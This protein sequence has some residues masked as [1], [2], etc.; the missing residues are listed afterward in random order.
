MA[1]SLNSQLPLFCSRFHHHLNSHTNFFSVPWKNM[2]TSI[3]L[4][5]PF[6]LL[7][8]VI[9][10]LQQYPP[11]HTFLLAPQYKCD[12]TWSS[13]LK[14]HAHWTLELPLHVHLFTV[15]PYKHTA[16]YKIPTFPLYLHY[17]PAAAW[18]TETT[19]PFQP[20]PHWQWTRIPKD[21]TTHPDVKPGC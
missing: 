14:L 1:S 2:Y 7:H 17:L 12:T 13:W 19:T 21:P 5:P 6:C 9:A 18:N 11:A 10:H 4:N 20:I 15:L 16:G 8:R 3:Y